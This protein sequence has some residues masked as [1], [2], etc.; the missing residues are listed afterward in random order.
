MLTLNPD[1]AYVVGMQITNTFTECVLLDFTGKLKSSLKLP[2]R[3]KT[4]SANTWIT[5]IE[6][7]FLKNIENINLRREQV[8]AIGII[9]PDILED[10][11][12]GL[13]QASFFQMD[14]QKLQHLFQQYFKI[15]TICESGPIAAAMTYMWDNP[16][17]KVKNLI[18]I[19]LDNSVGMVVIADGQLFCGRHTLCGGFG[20]TVVVP[21]GLSCRCGKKGC[22]EAYIGESSLIKAAQREYPGGEWQDRSFEELG[23]KDLI[24]LAQNQ[25]VALKNIFHRAGAILG[26]AISGWIQFF[27]PD[28]VII[29]GKITQIGN[30]FFLPLQKALKL[31]I[32]EILLTRTEITI[33]TWQPDTKAQGAALL[34]L[35]NTY[36]ELSSEK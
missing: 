33:P 6:S 16:K 9:T 27:S 4:P 11:N 5:Q 18:V 34:A 25:N 36:E 20:H 8:A 19:T 3:V 24:D 32:D 23:I 28:K 1:A 7:A 21:G 2:L 17:E 12:G 26:L 14:K 31:Y 29:S 30:I 22:I 15:T 13:S 35:T 10:K